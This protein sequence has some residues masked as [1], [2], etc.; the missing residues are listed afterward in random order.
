MTLFNDQIEQEEREE[1]NEVKKREQ[2]KEEKDNDMEE[3]VGVLEIEDLPVEILELVLSWIPDPIT[4]RRV[5]QVCSRWRSAVSRLRWLKLV[6]WERR[7]HLR[8][9]YAGS[10]HEKLGTL[11]FSLLLQVCTPVLLAG[12]AIFLPHRDRVVHDV[13]GEIQL[14]RHGTSHCGPTGEVI[15]RVPFQVSKSQTL[16]W[17]EDCHG[18]GAVCLQ[19]PWRRGRQG[20]LGPSCQGLHPFP[21]MLPGLVE[22]QP[23]TRYLLSLTLRQEAVGEDQECVGTVWGF[24]GVP[25]RTDQEMENIQKHFRWFQVYRHGLMSSVSSGQFPVIYYIS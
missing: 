6:V 24:Q 19:G 5:S 1:E 2:L 16:S 4:Q 3:C 9:P 18:S 8:L 20:T 21:V 13:S 7:L 14:V 23:E 22:L 10:L 11:G 17:Q 12:A 25:R 15:S